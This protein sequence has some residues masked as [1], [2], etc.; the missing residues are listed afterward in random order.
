MDVKVVGNE[1][2]S[3]EISTWE[4]KGHEPID[5]LVLLQYKNGGFNVGVL[6]YE[7]PADGVL[8]AEDKIYKTCKA[9]F[10]AIGARFDA[11]FKN[12]T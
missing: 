12:K 6:E 8:I 11:A 2:I 9:A 7:D 3:D 4:Y 10:T 5:C 1:A